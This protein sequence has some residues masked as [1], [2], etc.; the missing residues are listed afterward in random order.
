VPSMKVL[1]SPKYL[2]ATMALS[3][4]HTSSPQLLGYTTE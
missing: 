3:T 2:G 4:G 1:Q